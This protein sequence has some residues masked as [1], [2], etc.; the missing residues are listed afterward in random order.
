[1]NAFDLFWMAG[2]LEGEGCFTMGGKY[3]SVQC[4]MT[5][6]DSV[7]RLAVAAACGNV[8]GP[9]AQ[10]NPQHRPYWTWTVGGKRAVDLMIVLFPLMGDRRR[11]R[12]L[13]LVG[14]G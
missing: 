4:K 2:L 1:M 9:H 6:E 11:G 3:P 10:P 13:E 12:I 7:H 5:D 8:T 14:D